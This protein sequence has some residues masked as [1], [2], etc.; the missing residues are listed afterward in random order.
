MASTGFRSIDRN[1]GPAC[2]ANTESLARV[3]A[4]AWIS[5][6]GRPRAPNSNGAPRI[7]RI[8][9]SATSSPNGQ[10]C[11]TTSCKISTK[12]P[13][14]PNIATGPNT[15]SWCT[16][17]M[18]STPPVNCFA[19]NTPSRRA[20]GAATRAR[21][22]SKSKFSS[23]SCIEFTLSNTPPIS[24]LCKISGDR[25]FITTGNPS[26]CAA[27]MAVSAVSQTRSGAEWIPACASNT[28]ACASLG[29]CE[30]NSIVAIVG[31]G[32][33]GVRINAR[34]N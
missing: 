23:T 8:M 6:T 20:V 31:A 12:I 11:K 4:S 10:R 29:V 15:G 30:G 2:A 28:F 13:P 18:H 33:L 24:D 32:S 19:T 34:P 7:E 22:M 5:A 14:K 17:M 25:I 16:P 27:S 1:L 3:C 21:C 9:C 26:A